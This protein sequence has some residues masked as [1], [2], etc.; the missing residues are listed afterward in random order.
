MNRDLALLLGRILLVAIFPIAAYLKFKGW[1]G[2]ATGTLAKA[3]LPNPRVLGMAVIAAELVLP[4]LIILG[5]FTRIAA[6][7]M[8]GFVIVATYIG[9]PIWHDSS[10]AQ[11]YNFMKN[12]AMIGGFL[13]LAAFGSGRFALRPSRA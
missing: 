8:I 6:L 13:I 2:F 11:I 5:L 10:T 3:G 1:P 12:L 4:A 9:H 7:A